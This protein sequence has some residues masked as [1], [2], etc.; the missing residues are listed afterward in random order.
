M[1][2]ESSFG[3]LSLVIGSFSHL[4]RGD[5]AADDV[6]RVPKDALA[7]TRRSQEWPYLRRI[8]V[9]SST[10][11]VNKDLSSRS[12]IRY[13]NSHETKRRYA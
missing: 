5:V 13:M 9:D 1:S 3:I 10:T 11:G 2:G 8:S 7:G 12:V 4:R 6:R